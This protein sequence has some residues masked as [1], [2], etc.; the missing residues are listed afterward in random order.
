MTAA[1]PEAHAIRLAELLATLSLA[2]DLAMD[3]PPETAL[4]TCL[5]AVHIARQL[6]VSEEQ[7]S[8]VF[9]TSLLRHI[10]YFVGLPFQTNLAS[11]LIDGRAVTLGT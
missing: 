4:R 11:A 5:L 7:V 2:T 6:G 3:F 8:D 9:Y 1:H 10:G